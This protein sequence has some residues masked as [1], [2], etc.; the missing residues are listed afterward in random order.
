MFEI[1]VFVIICFWNIFTHEDIPPLK[2]LVTV[3]NTILIT[4]KQIFVDFS[5]TIL[6]PDNFPRRC[7]TEEK[8]RHQGKDN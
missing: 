2:I 6:D 1:D 4:P 3:L 7:M 5:C 8:E